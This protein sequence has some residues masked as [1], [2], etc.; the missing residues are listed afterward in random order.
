MLGEDPKGLGIARKALPGDSPEAGPGH[1][2]AP[3]EGLPA[4]YVRQVHLHGGHPTALRASKMAMLVW[5]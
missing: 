3:A 2:G 1:I 4:A 5:V